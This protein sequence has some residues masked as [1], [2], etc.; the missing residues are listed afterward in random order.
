[1]SRYRFIDA[2]K[3]DYPVAWMCRQL[4]VSKSGYFAWSGRTPSARALRDEELIATIRRIFDEHRGRYGSRR[5]HQELKA[6]GQ[7]VGLNRVERLMR[8]AGLRGHGKRR[9]KKTTDSTH[10]LPV[11][12]N[13][14]RRE[15]RAEKP[16]QV[17]AGDI[18]YIWTAQ[19]WLY[20]AVLLDLF[21][22]TV[23]GWKMSERITKKLAIDA[24][25]MAVAQ[26]GVPDGLLHHSDRGSQYAS[27]D[28][29]QLLD[30]HGIIVSMSRK[31]D[32]WDNAVS[33]S[34]FASLE[35]E[36]LID[37][38]FHRRDDAR[39]AVFEYI[40]G[41]YNRG[42]RHSTLGYLSPFE[43]E[44]QFGL[45]S[46]GSPAG[47]LPSTVEPDVVSE[48]P[49]RGGGPVRSNLVGEVAQRDLSRSALNNE[50]S[51]N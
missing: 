27:H 38:F 41:Y 14:L 39:Q 3:A 25:Q 46:A 2:E 7:D 13:I 29:R 24:L 47:R 49:L 10:L 16:N 19:G 9:F 43:Y 33:E 6:Q 35:K 8:E 30:A 48:S 23:I 51:I 50:K 44:R 37:S 12:P 36:L 1:M 21:S 11:A 26:R 45:G 18:T 4:D 42:R 32:C 40:E 22:R 28:Y 5:I 20:L 17:W 34:F 31:G 15:F